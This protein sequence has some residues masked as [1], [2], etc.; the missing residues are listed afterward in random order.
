MDV[1]IVQVQ[2]EHARDVV[3]DHRG[4]VIGV[5]ERQPLVGKLIARDQHGIIVCVYEERTR[6]TRDAQG[7]I[8]GRANLLA[9]LLFKRR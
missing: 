8:V 1:T 5:I 6:T 9:A 7:G 3:R 4:T 2:D